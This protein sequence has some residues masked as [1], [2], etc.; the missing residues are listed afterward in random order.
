MRHLSIVKTRCMRRMKRKEVSEMSEMEQMY[1]QYA[2]TVYR[3]LLSKVR[4]ADLAEDLTQETFYQ[5]IRSSGKYDGTSK[6]STWLC[7]I[8]KNVLLTYNRKHP[9]MEDIDE[10]PLI[11]PSAEQEA[12]SQSS[13]VDLLKK[14][15]DLSEPYREVLL[16]RVY[17][18]LSFR[19]IAEVMGKTE[20]WARV[21][22]Y[23]AKEQLRNEVL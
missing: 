5:A 22:F 2:Q 1:Q 19:E 9:A 3:F 17:G 12:L 4:D 13:Q 18:G 7:G 14:V 10:Q 20:N 16:L 11:S 23:R 21:T 8:A 15:H 6:V